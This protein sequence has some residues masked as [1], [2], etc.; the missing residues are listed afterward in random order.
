MCLI[1]IILRG[2]FVWFS[3]LLGFLLLLLFCF[4]AVS[5]YVALAALEFTM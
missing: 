1:V 4:E 2:Y 5:L 3:C